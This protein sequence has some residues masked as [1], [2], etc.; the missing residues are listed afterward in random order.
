ME[1][2]IKKICTKCGVEKTLDCYHKGKRGKFGV[3]AVCKECCSEY[4]KATRAKYRLKNK[5]KIYQYRLSNKHNQ[6]KLHA[7]WYQKNKEYCNEYKKQRLNSN[8]NVRLH[9]NVKSK[10]KTAIKGK[11]QTGIELELLGCSIEEL[12]IHLE[13]QFI[14]GMSWDN[15]GNSGWYIN[16]IIPYSSFNL[17]DTEQ[18]KKCF[19]YTNLQPLW[20]KDKNKSKVNHFN[21]KLRKILRKRI[22]DALKGNSKTKSTLELLGCSIE[23]LKLHLE[24][25]FTEGMSW[26]NHG[27]FGWHI[28]HVLPCNN[29]D[30]T[31]PEQQKKCFHYSNLQPLWWRD[32]ITKSD[33]ILNQSSTTIHFT[34]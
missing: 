27:Q 21:I 23:N 30:L 12:K 28:D 18:Q 14:E 16:C 8:V 3:K 34:P 15:Y 32:N 7:E 29:F 2:I 4:N 17:S 26:E 5:D 9:S 20:W 24:S 11:Y 22:W 6:A 25:K 10:I 1:D 31:D 19:N 33:K 13:N